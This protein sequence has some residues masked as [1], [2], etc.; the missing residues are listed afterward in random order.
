MKKSNAQQLLET[1]K[2][3]NP[4]FHPS[5]V[6]Y[7]ELLRQVEYADKMATLFASGNC[8]YF[9]MNFN[10]MKID[11]ISDSVF[12]ILGMSKEEASVDTL[13]AAWHPE[14]LKKMSKKEQLVFRFLYKEIPAKDRMF[15]KVSYINRLKNKDGS[16]KRILHQSTA[17]TLTNDKKIERTFCVET[18]LTHLN[19]PISDTVSFLGLKGRASFY[20]DDMET[21]KPFQ[22]KSLNLSDREIQILSLASKGLTSQK[23]A[24]KL[25]LSTHTV[26]T[27]KRNMLNKT[28]SKTII[29]LISQCIIEG[30]L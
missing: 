26:N 1:F 30:V 21:I 23:I 8:F 12:N 7:Q 24:D 20:S 29:Q 27:H 17:I 25:S 19:I 5:K 2:S 28:D 9:I 14:D 6:N 3:H 10:E 22:K 13:L 11:Y 4:I 15:Y 16:Y 18:D